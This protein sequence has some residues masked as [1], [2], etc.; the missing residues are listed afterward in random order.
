MTRQEAEALVAAILS[1]RDGASDA[2]ALTAVAVYPAW[3]SGVDYKAGERIRHGGILYRVVQSH[4]SQEGWEP[5]QVP[6]LFAAISL[7][8]GT[9]DNPI[10]AVRGMDYEQGKYYRDPEDG[11][12]YLC[13]RTATLQYL[14]HELVGQYFEGVKQ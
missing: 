12:T 9:A 8:D 4:T 14:P 5:D 13:T 6:A 7:D 2:L 1:M 3:R 10:E 11:L